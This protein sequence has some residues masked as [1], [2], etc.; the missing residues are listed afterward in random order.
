MAT[1]TNAMMT[2]AHD[3]KKKTV[4]A[5]V[6]CNINFT[7]MERCQMTNC[8]GMRLFKL[9]C[10]L[11]GKDSGLTGADDFLFTYAD[12]FFFPDPEPLATENR[13]F[14]VVLGEGVL[15]EDWGEAEIF[16]LI[17][18]INLYTLVQITRKTNTAAHSF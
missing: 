13:I 17:K 9:K 12:V 5:I 16:G 15:D 10:Q 11:W 18:L 3:H 4:R 6:K 2:L 7:P 8:P 14:D 1:I